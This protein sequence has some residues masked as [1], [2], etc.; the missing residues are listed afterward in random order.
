LAALSAT[1]CDTLH[2]TAT[3]CN[4]LQDTS[5]LKCSTSDHFGSLVSNTLQHAATRC[6]TLQQAATLLTST[7][8]PGK[9]LTQQNYSYFHI[10]L[11]SELKF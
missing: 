2:L 8:L 11:R 7:A 1:L 5:L 9:I 6:N 10:Q 3:S 4:T